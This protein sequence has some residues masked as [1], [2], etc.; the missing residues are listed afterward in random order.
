MN[1]P[2]DFRLTAAYPNPFNPTTTMKLFMPAAGQMQVEV[3]NLLGQSVAILANGYMEE[4]KYDLTWDASNVSSGI[5]FV[6]VQADGFATTQKLML[7]K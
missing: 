5:Y 1:L 3:Y 2:T 6:K 7:V 4:G